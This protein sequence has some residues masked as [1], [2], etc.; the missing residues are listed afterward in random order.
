MPNFLLRVLSSFSAFFFVLNCSSYFKKPVN[1]KKCVG[2]VGLHV[3]LTFLA[4]LMKY[5]SLK[6]LKNDL[7]MGAF[8]VCNRGTILKK[9]GYTS[10]NQAV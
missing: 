10:F 6:S 2:T 4:I 5:L 1:Y 9:A 8:R 3:V 7:E